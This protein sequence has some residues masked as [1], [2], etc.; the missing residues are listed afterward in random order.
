MAAAR[1]ESGTS[2]TECAEEIPAGRLQDAD[3]LAMSLVRFMRL[4]VRMKAQLSAEYGEVDHAAFVLLAHL[5]GDGPQRLTTLA[6]SVLSD[7]STVSRQTSSLV[8]HGLIERTPDPED[9]R[10]SLLAATD[11]GERVYEHARYRRDAYLAR[12][13]RRWS[14]DEVRQLTGLLE[15][16]TDDVE[17][18]VQHGEQ[19]GA[20]YVRHEGIT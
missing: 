3:Q 19:A 6:E 8:K 7:P 12:A 17:E 4:A 20:R 15:R 13:V 11:E 5:V 16:L 14:R 10:A 18:H 1:F 2:G 9:H